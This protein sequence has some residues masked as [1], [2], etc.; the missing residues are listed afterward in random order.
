MHT[1][2]CEQDERQDDNAWTLSKKPGK[3]S[4]LHGALWAL[5]SLPL[6]T[7]VWIMQEIVLAGSDAFI[8][9]GRDIIS[10][11]VMDERLKARND[12]RPIDFLEALERTLQ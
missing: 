9:W 5:F 7:R 3:L 2:L 10:F 8:M 11:K 6:W 12:F 1:Y 4:A